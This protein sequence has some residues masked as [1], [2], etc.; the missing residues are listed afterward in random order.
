MSLEGDVEFIRQK[1]PETKLTTMS[2]VLFCVRF[3]SYAFD[4]I[5]RREGVGW[6]ID[7][8]GRQRT[9]LERVGRGSDICGGVSSSKEC[10]PEPPRVEEW[11]VL[12]E[13]CS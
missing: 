11:C 10:V 1:L 5:P 7:E 6:K 13:R 9:L 3:C 2:S 4:T 12:R 8:Q